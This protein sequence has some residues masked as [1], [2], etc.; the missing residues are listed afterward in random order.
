MIFVVF[1]SDSYELFIMLQRLSLHL[2]FSYS[3]Y[4]RYF[5]KDNTFE[6][7]RIKR[8][9]E[10]MLQNDEQALQRRN[11]R[12]LI[13]DTEGPRTLGP[14][15]GYAQEPLL[16]LVDT[17]TP[18]AHIVDDI[19][20]YVSVALDKTPSHPA[21]GLTHD[22][23]A[24]IRLYTM[25]WGDNQK[26]LYRTLN[27]TLNNR[28]REDL[29][30]WFKYLKLFLTA[31]VKI[32]CAPQ[33]TVWR[34]VRKNV[35][36]E[37]PRGTQ[38]KWW[39]F[40]SCTQTLTVLENDMYLGN[41]GERTLF[42]IEVFNGKNISDHSHFD[43]EDEILLLPGTYMEVQSQLDQPSDLHIIH[44]KQ[45]IPEEILIEP[46]FEGILYIFDDLF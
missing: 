8:L 34:G 33:Q 40:S 41:V 21:D 3:R 10:K 16:P 44:L 11:A 42:S 2:Y 9:P 25:E 30:P 23:A 38:V 37:F 4:Q 7:S 15:I 43:T 19:F 13:Q 1:E 24:A 22:E 26:S 5:Q 14:I 45:K 31:L 35:K 27:Y 28:D 29:R 20:T 39:S 6:Y 46:P 12:L 32:P 17:C 36:D 18:L